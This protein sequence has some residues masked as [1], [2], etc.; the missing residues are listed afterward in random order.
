MEKYTIPYK[1][2]D[3]SMAS[4]QAG[5]WVRIRVTLKNLGEIGQLG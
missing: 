3:N 4:A 1:L 5:V 2:K